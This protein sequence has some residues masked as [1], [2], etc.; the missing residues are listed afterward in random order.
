MSTGF[1]YEVER[2]WSHEGAPEFHKATLDGREIGLEQLIRV[3]ESMRVK[4]LEFGVVI[5]AKTDEE[6]SIEG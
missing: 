4:L 1:K 5:R 6:R 2:P 3:A